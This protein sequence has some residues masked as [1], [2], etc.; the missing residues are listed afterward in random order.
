M[1]SVMFD[2]MRWL[3]TRRG[4]SAP[5]VSDRAGLA[6]GR[7]GPRC[8]FSRYGTEDKRYGVLTLFTAI[9]SHAA[10]STFAMMI[11]AA[12]TLPSFTV[13]PQ[14]LIRNPKR[15]PA[16]ASDLLSAPA[17]MSRPASPIARHATR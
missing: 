6:T 12:Q 17:P 15:T 5:V 3:R 16:P 4:A 2:G 14:F 8:S 10:D 1:G 9:E 7:G 13:G 11:G